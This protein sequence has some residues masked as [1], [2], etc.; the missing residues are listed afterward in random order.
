[1]KELFKL[2]GQPINPLS[3]NGWVWLCRDNTWEIRTTPVTRT[4]VLKNL[5]T[6]LVSTFDY[7]SQAKMWVMNEVFGG[8]FD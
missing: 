6:G 3:H 1:M 5:K 2:V 4:T 7:P 8:S